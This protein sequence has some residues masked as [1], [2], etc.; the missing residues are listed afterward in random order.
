MFLHVLNSDL[1]SMWDAKNVGYTV[2]GLSVIESLHPT[3]ARRGR[4]LMLMHSD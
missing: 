1:C 3:G 4:C 2:F